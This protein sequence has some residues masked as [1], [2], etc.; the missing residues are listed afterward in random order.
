MCM[1]F[2]GC[3]RTLACED[4]QLVLKLKTTLKEEGKKKD[5]PEEVT[6]TIANFT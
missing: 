3:E 5:F 2:W 6:D 4:T 1:S